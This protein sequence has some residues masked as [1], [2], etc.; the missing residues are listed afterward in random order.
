[1]INGRRANREPC[2]RNIGLPRHLPR[3]RAA[4]GEI[5]PIPTPRVAW[6]GGHDPVGRP[7][8]RAAGGVRPRRAARRRWPAGRARA[9]GLPH[10]PRVR[11]LARRRVRAA[12]A[13]RQ[14]P[15]HRAGG[16]RHHVHRPRHA[17]RRPTPNCSPGPAAAL[18]GMRRLGVTTVECKSGYGLDLETE[19]RLLRVYQTLAAHRSRAGS[20]PPSWARTWCP[21]STASDRQAYLRL[22]LDEMIPAVAR[23]GLADCCDVFVED[24]AFSV[25]EAREIFRAGKAAGLAPEAPRRP[26]L[27]RRRRGAGRRGGGAVAP[28]TWSASPTPASP[29]WRRRGSWR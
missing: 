23:G 3:P 11:R 10:A 29:R 15:R 9:G 6:D 4:Q 1:M 25:D 16:R 7:E 12:P 2:L 17:A 13:G 26:A 21:P 18:A 20:C 14:L 19:L 22:L 5:H 27:R 24:T 8:A 28:I